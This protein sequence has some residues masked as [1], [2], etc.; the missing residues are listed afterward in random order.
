MVIFGVIGAN[1]AGNSGTPRL[2]WPMVLNFENQQ[3]PG[4]NM[5]YAGGWWTTAG[6]LTGVFHARPCC[7]RSAMVSKSAATILL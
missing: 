4:R 1:S 2:F 7:G 5:E 3:K 6:K